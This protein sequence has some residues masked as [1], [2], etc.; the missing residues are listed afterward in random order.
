MLCVNGP[1]FAAAYLN[2]MSVFQM[3]IHEHAQFGGRPFELHG[4]LEDATT[5]RL[6]P[7][8]SVRVIRGWSVS[9]S[10]Y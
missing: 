2:E 5:M 7:V 3:V 8:I 4:D 6:S 10:I 1:L 9:G